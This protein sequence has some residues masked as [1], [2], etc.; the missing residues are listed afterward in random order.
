VSSGNRVGSAL[1]GM[2]QRVSSF[3]VGAGLTAL[4]TQY[5]IY[6]EIR[7][8]NL[9]MLDKQKELETRLAKLESGSTA[10]QKK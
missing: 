6:A 1:S 8:G 10:S 2:L 9:R 3:L 7:D 5:Y 4:G